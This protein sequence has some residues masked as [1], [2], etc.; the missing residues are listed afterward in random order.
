MTMKNFR[1]S[2]YLMVSLAFFA[3]LLPADAEATP[4]VGEIRMFAGSFPPAGW[5]FCNGQELPISENET[6]FNVIGTTY[7]GNGEN[8]FA[9]PDFQGRV[10][11][12]A[13]TSPV[14]GTTYVLDIAGNGRGGSETGTATYHNQALHQHGNLAASTGTAASASPEAGKTLAVPSALDRQ[15]INI[16]TDA[17]PDTTAGS[18]VRS[19]DGTFD[20]RQPYLGVS[21]IISLFGVFPSPT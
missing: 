20:N 12:G 7:G 9:L 18:V 5:A 19:G 2:L 14:S 16:Y 13:G 15:E 21:Y 1:R 6:L 3:C 8:T 10:A 11:V 4:Y 17:A